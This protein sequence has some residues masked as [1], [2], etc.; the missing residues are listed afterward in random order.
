MM[1]TYQVITKTTKMKK[2]KALKKLPH[3]KDLN[4]KKYPGERSVFRQAEIPLAK[5][6]MDRAKA[7][8]A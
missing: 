2:V 1:N 3:K 7:T 6:A 4:R 5:I 8:S